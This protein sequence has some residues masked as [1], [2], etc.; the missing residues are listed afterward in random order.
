MNVAASAAKPAPSR[1]E[2]M[3]TA[4]IFQTLLRLTL[5]TTAAMLATAMAA[6]AE[7]V[8]VGRL[9]VEPLAAMA[10]T[11]PMAMLMQMMSAG[12]MGG[13]VSS[14][15]SRAI[16]SGDIPRA[17]SL[18][19]HALAIATLA[20]VIFMVFF[21][22]LGPLIY[23]LLGGRD[24]SLQQALL[25]SNTLFSGALAVWWFNILA[26]ILRGTGNM[27][28]PSL[29]T[30][31]AALLQ[32]LLGAG[33][34][35]GLQ[36]GP[37]QLPRL[38]MPGLALAQIAV[39]AGGAL[40]LLWYLRSGRARLTL[41]L[42]GQQLQRR[43][44]MDILRVGAVACLSPLQTVLTVLIFTGLVA[45]FGTNAL[46]GYGIGARLEFLLVP[47]AFSIGVASVPMVGMAVGAGNIK[48]A[49]RVA[50]TAGAMA[51]TTL[52]I[53]GLIVVLFPD[54]WA[55]LF[56]D[57]TAVLESARSYL[58]AAGAGFGFFGTGL[59]LYFAS[60]GAGHIVGPVLAGT[61]RL[62]V[63]AL[64]GWWLLSIAAPAWT[65]FALAG[66]A[67]AIYG[68]ATAGFVYFTRWGRSL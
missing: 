8:Y 68:L 61:L 57:D 67:M 14:A 21:W 48:R 16:G 62:I 19:W 13:G 55:R 33:L 53:I 66:F 27:M 26:S 40:V 65:L 7:T 51:T 5:P 20:A 11:F 44:F 38:G 52:G 30:I 35:L 50:W 12:A 9:G 46:A 39:F 59:C 63:V 34:S 43:M 1:V 47:I 41:R 58:V 6:V 29:L 10:L 54:L 36:L 28:T 23:H 45:R 56:T 22:S 4:P 32:V 60:Q 31:L 37:V 64:G 42:R 17:H 15:I 25:Y 2:L 18:A 3:L 24:G 49:R